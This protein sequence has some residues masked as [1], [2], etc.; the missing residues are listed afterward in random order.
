VQGS[1]MKRAMFKT[2]LGLLF[3]TGITEEGSCGNASAD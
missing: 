1:G 2:G 3:E